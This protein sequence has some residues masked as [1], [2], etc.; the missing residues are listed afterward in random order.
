MRRVERKREREK[1]DFNFFQER[2]GEKKARLLGVLLFFFYTDLSLCALKRKKRGREG[3]WICFYAFQLNRIQSLSFE[4]RFFLG[5]NPSRLV[6]LG[7]IRCA[8]VPFGIPRRAVPERCRNSCRL[9]HFL[10]SIA[11]EERL[12][13][14]YSLE[15]ARECTPRLEYLRFVSFFFPFIHTESAFIRSREKN[16]NID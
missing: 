7:A 15:N 3:T 5:T 2:E 8:R 1:G 13:L 4:N 14:R 6:A 10:N 9:S 12:W 16:W 11:R